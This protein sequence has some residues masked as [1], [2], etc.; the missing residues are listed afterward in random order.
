MHEHDLARRGGLFFDPFE[1]G[2]GVGRQ[3]SPPKSQEQRRR[4]KRSTAGS[5]R[6]TAVAAVTQDLRRLAYRVESASRAG[7]E[8]QD[9]SAKSR[10]LP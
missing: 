3:A 6:D 9:G 10:Q 4:G 7:G 1:S 5:R 2:L 8:S